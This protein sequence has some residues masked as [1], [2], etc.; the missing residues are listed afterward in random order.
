M[1][2][3]IIFFTKN[4]LQNESFDNIMVRIK[5]SENTKL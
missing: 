5:N 1:E 2:E 4:P 3:K